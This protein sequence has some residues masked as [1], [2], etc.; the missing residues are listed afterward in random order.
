VLIGTTLQLGNVDSNHRPLTDAQ[1]PSGQIHR[2]DEPD[3]V[4]AVASLVLRFLAQ[5]ETGTLTT[6]RM[7]RRPG[8]L[9]QPVHGASELTVTAHGLLANAKFLG[10]SL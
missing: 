6:H 9:G 8:H 4:S 3:G 10:K 5:F 1:V 2:Y 7:R